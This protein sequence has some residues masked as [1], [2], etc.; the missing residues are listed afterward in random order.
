[1][2][3]HAGVLADVIDGTGQVSPVVADKTTAGAVPEGG[4]LGSDISGAAGAVA[5][6]ALQGGV[7]LGT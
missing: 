1:M 2:A 5:I 3:F 7:S 6:K 4:I